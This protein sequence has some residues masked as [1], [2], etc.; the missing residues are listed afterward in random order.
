MQKWCCF[1]VLLVVASA[2]V[3]CGG[4]KLKRVPIEGVLTAMG[5]PVGGATV[6]FIPAQGTPGEGGIGQTGP[7]GKFTLI[8]SRKD[9][10]GIPP[11]KYTVRVTRI[12]EPDGTIVSPDEPEANHPDARESIPAPYSGANSP[13]EATISESGGQIKLE[14]P[15]KVPGKMKS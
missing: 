9:D 8:S 15:A 10:P 7:D 12:M 3:G 13:L 4:D 1:P 11:G 14:I 6:Q 2:M 5:E